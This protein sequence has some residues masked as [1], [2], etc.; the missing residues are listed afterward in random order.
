[1]IRII[2]KILIICLLFMACAILW[3]LS[4]YGIQQIMA[5]DVSFKPKGWDTKPHGGKYGD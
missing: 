1:M 5:G 3:N 2:E 4:E